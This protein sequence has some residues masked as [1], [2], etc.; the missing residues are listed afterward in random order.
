[1]HSRILFMC[2]QLEPNSYHQLFIDNLFTSVNFAK[3]AENKT[4]SKVITLGVA[5]K[6]CGGVFTLVI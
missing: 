3:I 2:N 5:R 4:K 1:M 6:T